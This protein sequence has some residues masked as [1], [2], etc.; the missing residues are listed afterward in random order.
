MRPGRGTITVQ[1]QKGGYMAAVTDFVKFLG[2]FTP[3]ILDGTRT[4]QQMHQHCIDQR[5]E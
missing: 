4:G 5:G 1:P 3:A 2:L